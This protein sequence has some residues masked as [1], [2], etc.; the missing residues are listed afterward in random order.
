MIHR[1][2][3]RERG[4]LLAARSKQLP[5]EDRGRMVLVLF[6]NAVFTI[7]L[8]TV[9][10]GSLIQAGRRVVRRGDY[11]PVPLLR[12]AWSPTLGTTSALVAAQNLARPLL[13]RQLERW[14]AAKVAPVRPEARG[15]ERP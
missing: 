10:I 12:T 2:R 15:P 7:T 11:R 8:Q 9:W 13:V 14:V 5:A 6:G 4:R 3:R 1:A